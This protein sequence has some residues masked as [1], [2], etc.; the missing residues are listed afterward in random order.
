MP[1]A[2]V[3]A[4]P[5]LTVEFWGSAA[6]PAQYPDAGLPEVLLLGRSNA[7]KSSLVNALTGRRSI[8]RISKNPGRTQCLNFYEVE[9]RLFLTDAP[10]YGYAAVA[11]TERAG[12]VRLIEGYLRG[13]VPLVAVVQI[14][15]ARHDPSAQDIA[16]HRRA[17]MTARPVLVVA[18]KVDTVAQS[19]RALKL[20]AIQAQLEEADPPL[21]VSSRTGEGIGQLWARLQAWTAG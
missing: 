10:G 7:G 19:Q 11:R 16:W 1:R 8:A 21:A 18:H 6:R 13:R 15:D 9:G 3:P 12:W 20:R 4:Q 2:G 17:R 14:V 5:A